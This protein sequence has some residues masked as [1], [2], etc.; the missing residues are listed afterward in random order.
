MVA[1]LGSFEPQG[2]II[3]TAEKDANATTKGNVVAVE[4]NKWSVA[5]TSATGFLG[6]AVSTETA[7][8]TTVDVL[9]GGIV[10]VKADGAINPNSAVVVS[11][12]TAGEVQAS[13]TPFANGVLGIYLGH[14]DE[15]SGTTVPTAAADGDTIR[16]LIGGGSI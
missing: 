6:V 3:V 11:A 2:A 1:A 7:S 9:L 16:V 5:N 15:P 12:S 10:Y 13:A 8:S 4:S 14:E